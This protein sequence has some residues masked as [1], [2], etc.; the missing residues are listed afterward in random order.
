MIPVSDEFK[1]FRQSGVIKHLECVAA[2]WKDLS[3]FNVV[4]FVQ[5]PARG[6]PGH[7]SLV[8]HRLSIVLAV[9]FQIHLP[10][11]IRGRIELECIVSRFGNELLD[12][13]VLDGNGSILDQ[14][15]VGK[16]NFA[17]H[18]L[19]VVPVQSPTEALAPQD[20]VITQ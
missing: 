3:S 11:P 18:I 7:G 4:M 17:C 14:S 10:K 5:Q 16:G 20:F 8:N 1:V 6:V 13:F 12:V 19:K 9:R 15:W 2:N